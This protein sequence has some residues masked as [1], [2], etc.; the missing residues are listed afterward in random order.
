MTML[1][2]VHL[3]K[4]L[5]TVVENTLRRHLILRT[6]TGDLRKIILTIILIR[7]I[8]TPAIKKPAKSQCIIMLPVYGGVAQNNQ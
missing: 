2:F 8:K 1:C 7:N 6:L 3:A 4:S 5:L